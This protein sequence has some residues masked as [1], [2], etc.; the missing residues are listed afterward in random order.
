MAR[1]PDERVEKARK[2]YQKGK[3]LSEIAAKLGVPSGTV[4]RWKSTYKWDEM[5]ESECSESEQ[6]RSDKSERSDKKAN[7]QKEEKEKAINEELEL[8]S[9]N[10]E[11]TEKQRLFCMY[12]IRSFNAT[13]SYQKAYQCNYQMACGHGHELLKNVEIKNEIMRLKQ[14]RINRE[15]LSE[16]DI[17][18]KYMDI[19]FSDITDY[20]Q[21]GTEEI[22]VIGAFG[23]LKDKETGE[24]IT[25]VVNVVHFKPSAEVDGTII[26]EVKQGKD[27]A[28]IKLADRMKAL[29]W[30]AAHMDLATAEQKAKIAQINAQ[31]ERLKQDNEQEELA[32]DGFLQ[33]LEGNAAADWEGWT[34]EPSEES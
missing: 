7:A 17:F 1:A 9:K 25:K 18:Q 21:F 31:T 23:V 16:H 22:P 2:L 34:D 28:S 33:A 10:S 12:Y 26:S 4:R 6:K 29:D 20:L 19:A 30:L 5:Q 15:F 3:K 32:D 24:P 8:I 13:K 27:G 14:A 11:L